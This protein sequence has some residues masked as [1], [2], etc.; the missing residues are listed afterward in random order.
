M[1]CSYHHLFMPR[2]WLLQ[3]T[4]TQELGPH[5]FVP[6]THGRTEHIFPC[7]YGCLTFWFPAYLAPMVARVLSKSGA[8][9]SSICPVH[10]WAYGAYFSV[11]LWVLNISVPSAHW[12][13]SAGGGEGYCTTYFILHSTHIISLQ[14]FNQ[15]GTTVAITS[16]Q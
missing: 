8:W 7:T 6:C 5:Q 12:C 4:Q 11:C 2:T 13:I 1:Y 14:F 9:T 16:S 3:F 10:P 15:H